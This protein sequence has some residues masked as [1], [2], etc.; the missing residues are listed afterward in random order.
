[1][2]KRDK[3]SAGHIWAAGFHRVMACSHLVYIFKSMN[4]LFPNISN[5]FFGPR[6]SADNCNRGCWVHGYSGPPVSR[7]VSCLCLALIYGQCI[8]LHCLE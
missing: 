8:Q 7:N 1:V 5:F 2:R 4:R 3:S 6:P